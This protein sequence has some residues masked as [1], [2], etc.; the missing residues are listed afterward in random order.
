MKP[1]TVAASPRAQ[2]LGTWSRKPSWAI[3][4]VAVAGPTVGESPPPKDPPS[5]RPAIAAATTSKETLATE[6]R[7][8]ER[9]RPSVCARDAHGSPV[10]SNSPESGGVDVGAGEGF[11]VAGFGLGAGGM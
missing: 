10:L 11:G 9:T 4:C 2:P 7:P 3:V 5:S 6:S 8:A 1:G